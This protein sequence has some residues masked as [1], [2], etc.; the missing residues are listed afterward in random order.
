MQEGPAAELWQLRWRIAKKHADRASLVTRGLCVNPD[1]DTVQPRPAPLAARTCVCLNAEALS[2]SLLV[3]GPVS[4]LNT[5]SS[6]E[7]LLLVKLDNVQAGPH[8]LVFDRP[9][10]H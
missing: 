2:L 3:P 8:Q 7:E 10:S 9:C 1:L 4:H 6:P 5:P